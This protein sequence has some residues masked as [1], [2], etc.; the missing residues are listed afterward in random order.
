MALTA[1]ARRWF[2]MTTVNASGSLPEGTTPA[3]KPWK[4]SQCQKRNLPTYR[5]CG[6]CYA[7]PDGSPM[8]V[9]KPFVQE[10]RLI[11]VLFDLDST[12]LN[13]YYEHI[14]RFRA[15]EVGRV[16]DEP[17][18]SFSSLVYTPRKI[19][20]GAAR[21]S[22]ISQKML[23][24]QPEAGEVITQ[25]LNYCNSLRTSTDDVVLLISHYG[26]RFEF[27]L[28]LA[29]MQRH[30]VQWGKLKTNNI[31]F[32]DS[33]E[34]ISSL[35]EFADEKKGLAALYKNLAPTVVANSN[36]LQKLHAVL[37]SSQLPCAGDRSQLLP[38]IYDAYSYIDHALFF[39]AEEFENINEQSIESKPFDLKDEEV[40]QIHLA[41]HDPKQAHVII[42][43]RQYLIEENNVRLR[44]VHVL[45]AIFLQQTS[46]V[47]A[48]ANEEDL[49]VDANNKS[50]AHNQAWF[51]GGGGGGDKKRNQKQPRLRQRTLLGRRDAESGK[52][53][54]DVVVDRT[55][56]IT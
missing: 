28:L 38:F 22:K 21:A 20:P 47:K 17:K 27:A 54:W 23:E 33:W 9:R 31:H 18:S 36:D 44:K 25:F 42:R 3:P 35:P 53:K 43:Q 29:E 46:T 13:V 11:Y 12:G 14:T 26:V 51:G 49:F 48:A 15:Q 4:C 39:A 34:Y 52:Y 16:Q 2:A 19:E 8:P 24:G 37:F 50:A 41:L 7:K 30:E 5:F 56:L 6:G 45:G 32:L 1:S 40:M 10:G 55:L